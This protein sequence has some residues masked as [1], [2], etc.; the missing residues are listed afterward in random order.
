MGPMRLVDRHPEVDLE[1]L[2]AHFVPPPRFR[3]A[4]FA[5]YRPDPRYPSQALAKERLRRWVKDRPRGLFRPRL[6]GP[7]GIYLDGGFGVGKTHLLVAA[8]LEAPAPKAFLT[9]EELTY[10]LGLMGLREGARRFAALRYLFLDEFELD[11]PGNA[12]M[13]T[14]FLAL[15]MERGLRVA[16]I[17]RRAV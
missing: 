14:H 6:P 11:D 8:Y 9:F 3:G 12:Q 15:T 5:A 10:T 7:Q 2:L 1:K 13:I 4:T 16:T 17:Q